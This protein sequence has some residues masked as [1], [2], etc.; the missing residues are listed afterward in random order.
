MVRAI[1]TQVLSMMSTLAAALTLECLLLPLPKVVCLLSTPIRRVLLRAGTLSTQRDATKKKKPARTPS[2]S[3][4]R[5]ILRPR[6]EQSYT[7][8]K[9]DE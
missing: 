7:L 8:A 2:V 1:T 4:P 6:I 9:F 3:S 5:I